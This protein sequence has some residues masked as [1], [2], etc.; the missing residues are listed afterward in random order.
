MPK[1]AVFVTLVNVM[2][3]TITFFYHRF[4]SGFASES[5]KLI[6]VCVDGDQCLQNCPL[7]IYRSFKV[8]KIMEQG[9][10]DETP[11]LCDS[12]YIRLELATEMEIRKDTDHKKRKREDDIRF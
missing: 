5:S 6:L 9:E 2:F 3:G 4:K 8:K 11:D 1:S 12:P 10:L 7:L